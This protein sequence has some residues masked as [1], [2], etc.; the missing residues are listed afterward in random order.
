D[1]HV[2][3]PMGNS[4]KKF[5]YIYAMYKVE[6][7]MVP[8]RPIM[9]SVYSAEC[10]KVRYKASKSKRNLVFELST[11]R[12]VAEIPPVMAVQSSE[13]IPLRAGDGEVVWRSN[14]P[15]K[16]SDGAAFVTVSCNQA[17]DVERI[18][19]FFE[20]EADYNLFKFIHPLYRRRRDGRKKEGT[21]V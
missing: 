5:V 21:G 13:R 4:P 11:D 18:R 2:R 17:V 20:E 15:I 12:N 19:L 14:A 7:E 8:S 10:K 16:F 6:D 1:R 9:I 3:I